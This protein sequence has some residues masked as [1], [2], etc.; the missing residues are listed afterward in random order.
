LDYVA[1]VLNIFPIWFIPLK[2]AKQERLS[3]NYLQSDLIISVG[4]WADINQN[5]SRFVEINRDLEKTINDLKG[6]KWLYAHQYYSREEFWKIYDH[7]WYN[8]LRDK[9]FANEVFPD[10]YDKTKVSEKYKS[11]VLRAIWKNT[12]RSLKLPVS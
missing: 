1:N 9:Y 4:I 8:T 6:R 11:S 2:P 12:F 5:Y 3:L 10:M 7:A